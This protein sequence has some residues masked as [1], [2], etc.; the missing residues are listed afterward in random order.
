[1]DD[2]YRWNSF[3]IRSN[4]FNMYYVNYEYT[5]DYNFNQVTKVHHNWVQYNKVLKVHYFVNVILRIYLSHL[6]YF[7]L[8]DFQNILLIRSS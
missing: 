2:T 5:I 8:Y 6:Y 3:V 7:S 4:F 1:M